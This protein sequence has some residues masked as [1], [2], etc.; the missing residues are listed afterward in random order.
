VIVALR[1]GDGT[2]DTTPDPE[3]VLEVGDVM[4][5]VGTAAELR[6]L[7]ELFAPRETVAT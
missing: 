2:F 4:I 1:K 7:E 3:A 5:A 6:R